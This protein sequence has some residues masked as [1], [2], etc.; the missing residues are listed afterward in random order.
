VR[1]SFFGRLV[2]A[3]VIVVATPA[4]VPAH[5]GPFTNVFVFGESL[6]DT[7]N[8]KILSPSDDSPLSAGPYIDG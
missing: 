7:G 3:T 1:S 8:L 4:S 6:S 2:S 5:A